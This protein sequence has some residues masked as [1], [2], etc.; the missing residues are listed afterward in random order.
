MNYLDISRWGLGRTDLGPN[1]CGIVSPTHM[2]QFRLLHSGYSIVS[3]VSLSA[4]ILTLDF[5][6]FDDFRQ[7]QI[8]NAKTITEYYV[9]ST[10]DTETPYDTTHKIANWYIEFEYHLLALQK[11]SDYFWTRV[12]INNKRWMSHL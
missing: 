2:Y 9:I 4:V 1:F 5:S 11:N 12:Y 3:R 8:P 10:F 6:N 7:L